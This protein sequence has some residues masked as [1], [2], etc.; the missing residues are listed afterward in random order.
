MLLYLLKW[1]WS[2]NFNS[3]IVWFW[4]MAHSSNS[5]ELSFNWSRLIHHLY[6]LSVFSWFRLSCSLFCRQQ[7]SRSLGSPWTPKGLASLPMCGGARAP[8]ILS[9]HNFFVEFLKLGPSDQSIRVFHVPTI[10]SWSPCL[11]LEKE[12]AS[13]FVFRPCMDM[14]CYDYLIKFFRGPQVHQ[15][16]L[17]KFILVWLGLLRKLGQTTTGE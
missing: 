17:L 12:L 10:C 6:F 7:P 8:P 2:L 16:F 3:S 15:L 1:F 9:I 5:H 11:P 14:V 4:R 13:S